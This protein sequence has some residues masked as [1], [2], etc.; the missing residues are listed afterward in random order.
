MHGHVAQAKYLMLVHRLLSKVTI[1]DS[2][3]LRNDCAVTAVILLA[4]SLTWSLAEDNPFSTVIPPDA[5]GLETLCK[6]LTAPEAIPLAV[7]TA[8]LTSSFWMNCCRANN[9]S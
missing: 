6:A 4:W 3:S 8:A 9:F 5:E 2:C 1:S 7:A